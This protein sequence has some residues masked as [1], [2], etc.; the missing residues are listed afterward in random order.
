M[1]SPVQSRVGEIEWRGK[2]ASY[3][4]REKRLMARLR[5]A[6]DVEGAALVHELKA[7]FPGST[8]TRR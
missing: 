6:G 2:K 1:T 4:A 8:L 7:A 5:E 3:T